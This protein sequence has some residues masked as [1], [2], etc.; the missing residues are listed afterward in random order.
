MACIHFVK[1]MINAWATSNR[2]L[3]Q[4]WKDLVTEI[5]DVGIQLQ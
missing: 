5:F 4:I 2:I 3:P 1:Q